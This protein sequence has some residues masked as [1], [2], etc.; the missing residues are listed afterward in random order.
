MRAE[1]Q[2]VVASHPLW[3]R[4]VCLLQV[5]DS[6]ERTLELRCLMSAANSSQAFDL[7][8]AVREQ[9]IKFIQQQHPTSLPKTRSVVEPTDQPFTLDPTVDM[10]G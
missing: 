8:C 5:T 2:R 1:L 6:K 3:D 9:L 10:A 7:R 4:R